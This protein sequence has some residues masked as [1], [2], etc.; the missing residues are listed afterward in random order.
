MKYRIIEWLEDS[1]CQI[2]RIVINRVDTQTMR[3]SGIAICRNDYGREFRVARV[4]I[5]G[6]PD[7]K[8]AWYRAICQDKY[9]CVRINVT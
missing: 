4:E 3:V 1:G 7:E 2:N 5:I 8:I 6:K 9:G